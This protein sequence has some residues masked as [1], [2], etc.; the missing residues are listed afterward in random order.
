M[1]QDTSDKVVLYSGYTQIAFDLLNT[2]KYASMQARFDT[3]LADHTDDTI[4]KVISDL[5]SERDNA[6]HDVESRISEAVKNS[7]FDLVTELAILRA[8]LDSE[9]ATKV[10]T[11]RMIPASK[12]FEAVCG[13][14]EFP[15]RT[16]AGNST[17]SLTVDKVYK[18]SRYNT[19][20]YWA[21][22]SDK[23]EVYAVNES[24][25]VSDKVFTLTEEHWSDLYPFAMG[26]LTALGMC[27]D[28]AYNDKAK[29]P[30]GTG[31][32]DRLKLAEASLPDWHKGLG[33][34]GK[35]SNG[36]NSISVYTV[37]D[38]ELTPSEFLEKFPSEKKEDSKKK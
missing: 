30:E 4:G 1:S 35:T 7:D 13:E 26:S 33:L 29:V 11:A 15:I 20:R 2:G 32:V 34:A 23:I 27:H 37:G 12:A 3:L 31:T 21:V 5:E 17:Q 24:S 9:Y 16:T 18:V 28:M 22:Y 38:K 25:K 36:V 19:T 10:A 8:S 6:K 14:F